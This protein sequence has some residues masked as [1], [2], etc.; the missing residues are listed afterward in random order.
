MILARG[1][2]Q[3]SFFQSIGDLSAGRKGTRWLLNI[4][5]MT[6]R[7]QAFWTSRSF[8]WLGL[9]CAAAGMFWAARRV[10][11]IQR[12]SVASGKVVAS[13]LNRAS[14]EDDG[15]VYSASIT[16]RWKVDGRDVERVF[17]QWGSSSS[18]ARYQAIVDGYKVGSETEVRYEPSRP[19]SAYIEA[20]YT[21]NFFLFP[22]LFTVFGL[23]FALLGFFILKNLKS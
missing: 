1:A 9:A 17:D 8:I 12:W 19:S 7:N 22:M 15:Y 16:V 11:A 21:L 14:G 5:S 20:G 18:L 10:A 4:G 13:K 3:C 6:S 2:D 23:A